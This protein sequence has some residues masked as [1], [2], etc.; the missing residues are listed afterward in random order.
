MNNSDIKDPIFLEAVEAIDS[1]N[2]IVLEKLIKEHPYLVKEK[3]A[4]TK[5][6]YFKDPYLLWFVADNPIRIEKLPRN[7]VTV[8]RLLVDEVKQ[9]SPDTAQ[10]QIAYTL[11]LVATGRIPR[12]CG[13]QI[14]MMD[15]L[16]GAGAE[17]GGGLGALAHGNIEAAEHLIN[18]GGKLTLPVAVGLKRKA[19]INR[20]LPNANDKEKLTA[21]TLAAFYGMTDMVSLLLKSGVNPNGYPHGDG[22]HHHATPLHQAVYSGSL[23]VVKLLIDAG[24]DLTATDKAYNGT[25]LGWA[26]YMQTEEGYDEAGKK[27]F[28][29]IEKHLKEIS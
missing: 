11:G 2:I 13:V 27:R 23:E 10:Q 25:P 3:L 20:L 16:M 8:T 21:L 29:V 12:E 6:G 22:F 18:R 4:T 9:Q 17:P 1:G 19:D 24:A 7:I 15:L 28:A 14:E 26:I 5:E